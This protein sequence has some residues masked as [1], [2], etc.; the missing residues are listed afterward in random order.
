MET[1]TRPLIRSWP[2][3]A[4][5]LLAGVC[6]ARAEAVSELKSFSVFETVDLAQLAQGDAKAVRGVPMNTG[7]FLSVQACWV[8]PGTPAQQAEALRR[9][10]PAQHSEMKIYLHS[11]GSNFSRLASAPSNSA[12]QSLA[13][14]TVGKSTEL[15]ISKAEAARLPSG[16]PATMSGPVASFWTSLLSARSSAGPF[17]QP[18][19]DYTGQA[20][21]P[22]DEIKGLLREQGKIQKQ[23][24]GLVGGKGDP[25]WELVEVDGKGVLTLGAS[26]NRGGSGGSMQAADVLYYASGGYYAAVTLYQMWP[27]EV[28]GKPSTLVWRGDLISSAELAGLAG[29]ERLGSESA[30]MKDVSRAIRL[31]RR[32]S[33]GSR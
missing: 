6:S 2:L 11:N 21:R 4:V 14:A 22:G 13:T 12:V 31:F 10:N 27:V 33:S 16:A 18:A 5:T 8:A 25:Y 26:Y 1:K 30:L 17:S 28:G 9:W 23:F 20:I 32:D 7:R 3:L 15:Q 19:Y 29:V 24:A